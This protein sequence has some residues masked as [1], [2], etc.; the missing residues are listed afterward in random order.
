MVLC[1]PRSLKSSPPPPP[2]SA[3]MRPG[4][5]GATFLVLRRKFDKVQ[6]HVA[7]SNHLQRSNPH[8][9]KKK[10]NVK[11]KSLFPHFHRAPSALSPHA[12]FFFFFLFEFGKVHLADGLH[13]YK[14]ANECVTVT[15]FSRIPGLTLSFF[16]SRLLPEPPSSSLPVLRLPGRPALF[17]MHRSL[18]R[19]RRLLLA[20]TR[21]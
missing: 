3:L 11:K 9:L 4:F 19:G 10:K 13:G 12:S 18:C 1:R 16:L 6:V 17:Q 8:R 7:V 5:P 2:L 15:R 21:S 14:R 20:D